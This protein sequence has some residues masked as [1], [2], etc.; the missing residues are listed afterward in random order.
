MI[1]V[2]THF[3]AL[4]LVTSYY[5]KLEFIFSIILLSQVFSINNLYHIYHLYHINVPAWKY[6]F[7]GSINIFNIKICFTMLSEWEYLLGVKYKHSLGLFNYSYVYVLMSI[8][9]SY[10]ES[11]QLNICFIF[12]LSFFPWGRIFIYYNTQCFSKSQ[13]PS[14]CGEETIQFTAEATVHP[15]AEYY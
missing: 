3:E 8:I 7:L 6:F 12:L 9:L 5:M 2:N 14:V 10:L 15:K 13:T 4:C 11:I 1:P